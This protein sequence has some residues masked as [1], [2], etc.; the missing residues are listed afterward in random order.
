M[1]VGDNM[2]EKMSSNC[3][4]PKGFVG[5]VFVSIM[6]SGHAIISQWSMQH[7]KNEKVEKALDIGCGGG[8]NL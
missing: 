8:A 6:N 4:L 7:L 3:K 5:R 2:F 1:R